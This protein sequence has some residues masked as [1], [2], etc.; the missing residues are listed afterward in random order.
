MDALS[1]YE[2]DIVGVG[3]DALLAVMVDDVSRGQRR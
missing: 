1:E 2:T 3:T